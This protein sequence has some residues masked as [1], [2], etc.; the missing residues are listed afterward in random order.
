MVFDIGE[1]IVLSSQSL[2]E[3]RPHGFTFF[4]LFSPWVVL[5]DQ[6]QF[7]KLF[8]L[9]IS[10]EEVSEGKTKF[11]KE[12]VGKILG[13]YEIIEFLHLHEIINEFINLNKRKS[14]QD[15]N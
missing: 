13:E 5:I 1:N 8:S 7:F 2:G 15:N 11:V 10:V 3:E 6:I 9:P 12:S 4:F 14:E